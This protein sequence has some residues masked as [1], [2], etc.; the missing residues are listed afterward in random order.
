MVLAR[1]AFGDVHYT[2]KWLNSENVLYLV[3]SNMLMG[4]HLRQVVFGR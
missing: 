1:V 3:A 2:L 4:M